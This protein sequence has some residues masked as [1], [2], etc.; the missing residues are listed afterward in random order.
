MLPPYINQNII[1]PI[2]FENDEEIWLPLNYAARPE[3]KEIYYVSSHGRIFSN[4]NVNFH[5]QRSKYLSFELSNT[6]YYRVHLV[7]KDNTAAHYS[8]HRLVLEAFFPVENMHNL[9]V[10]HINGNKLY[11]HLHNLEWT[12]AEEN[13]RHA[14]LNQFVPWKTGD[15]CSW[16]T[17]DSDKAD[18]IAMMIS[19]GIS[20][21]EIAIMLDCNKSVVT[22][23]AN[24]ISWRDSY[25]KYKLWRNRNPQK[26]LF[27]DEQYLLLRKYI[28][29][30]IYKYKPEY[31]RALCMEACKEL[32]NMPKINRSIY[33]DIMDL[34]YWY[35]D[36]N[37]LI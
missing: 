8:V 34:I 23:I 10:N 1:E 26:K 31:Y 6:G 29:N 35:L 37:G 16:S 9:F 7:R 36:S 13:T 20:Q 32:F 11:N 5:Q 19:Q 14:I 30:N 25:V 15:D 33:I 21:Y 28:A 12:T 2:M 3:I 17:I 4:G 18:K 22:N 27:T 24:G